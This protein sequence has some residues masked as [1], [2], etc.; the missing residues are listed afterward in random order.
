[1]SF[2]LAS[3][4]KSRPHLSPEWAVTSQGGYPMRLS[5]A[6]Q[7]QD[8]L[9][10]INVS[11]IQIFGMCNVK[12]AYLLEEAWPLEQQALFEGFERV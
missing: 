1:M 12:S 7:A 9:L 3:N 4:L 11:Q 8:V 5:D 2:V 6:I 10:L